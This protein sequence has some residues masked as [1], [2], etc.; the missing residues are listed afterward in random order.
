MG[1]L[2][3]IKNTNKLLK[4]TGFQIVKCDKTPLEVGEKV[5]LNVGSGDWSCKGWINLDYPSEWY[6][7]AQRKHKIIQ[8]DIRN[9]SIPFENGKVDLIYCSHV[10]EHI[11]DEYVKKLFNEVFRVLKKG[12]VARFCCPDAEFLYQVSTI[13]SDYWEWRKEWFA[14]DY[15]IAKTKPRSVDFLVREIATPKL[16]GYKGSINDE[17]YSTQ[18]SSMDMKD[19]LEYITNG[20]VFREKYVGDH[21]NYWTFDKIKK[22]LEDSGFNC[23][24]RSK[25][26]GSIANEMKNMDK[27]DVVYPN[28]S[29]YVEAVK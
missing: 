18:F 17:D 13:K 14:T 25:W 5:C 26:S 21:I 10:I 4:K 23:V 28:M 19:F 3:I 12:G 9:D 29:L 15:Y 7:K 20:L 16:L 8:Y 24:I 2:H 11:E 6:K 22:M 1:R 27:F